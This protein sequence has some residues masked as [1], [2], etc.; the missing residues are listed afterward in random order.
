MPTPLEIFLDPISL[1]I[2]AM[3]AALMIWE[4][5]FPGRKAATGQVLE[6]QRNCGF[7]SVLHGF[8]LPPDVYQPLS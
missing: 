4:A 2:I 3:Y 8:F 5:V 7:Y 1:W 6:A